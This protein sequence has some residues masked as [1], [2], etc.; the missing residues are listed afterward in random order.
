MT[1]EESICAPSG[2]DGRCALRKPTIRRW[3]S[4]TALL[5]GLVFLP[6]PLWAVPA[7][8]DDFR[9]LARA[10]EERGDWQE[11]CRWYDEALRND[12]TREE[13]REGYRRCLRHFHLQRRHRD[14][15]YRE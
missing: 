13:C 3:S 6:S 9:R 10:C 8:A 4:G 11:A 2:A 5:V 12:R 14:P 7:P 1:R 15:G